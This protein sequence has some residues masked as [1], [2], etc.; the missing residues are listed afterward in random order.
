MSLPYAVLSCPFIPNNVYKLIN[1][2]TRLDDETISIE[3]LFT[4]INAIDQSK[5]YAIKCYPYS[6][7]MR[8]GSASIDDT[9]L[10]ISNTTFANTYG[11]GLGFFYVK[12]LNGSFISNP[13]T[14]DFTG[15][16]KCVIVV[17]HLL[18]MI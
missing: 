4:F 10:I 12:Y 16:P 2:N 1:R 6:M 18:T 13:I 11:T 8:A 9:N 3:N 5:I 7:F 17:I 14:T 15:Y